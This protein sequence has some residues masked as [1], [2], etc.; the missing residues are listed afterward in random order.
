MY[1]DTRT[2]VDYDQRGTIGEHG[3]I[4]S[5]Q[6]ILGVN[7]EYSLED[8]L[9]L[10]MGYTLENIK[11]YDPHFDESWTDLDGGVA[12]SSIITPFMNAPNQT[13]HTIMV[14]GRYNF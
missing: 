3:A 5:R 13:N 7:G 12:A 11:S 14:S 4:W 6:H 1:I 2:M 8:N 10:A 9:A